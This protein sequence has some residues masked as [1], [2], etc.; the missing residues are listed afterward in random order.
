MIQ[1]PGTSSPPSRLKYFSNG[2][3]RTCKASFTSSF[4]P[5]LTVDSSG[6][7]GGSPTHAPL[8]QT[9]PSSPSRRHALLGKLAS[10]HC[11]KSCLSYKSVLSA[12]E[13]LSTVIE[14]WNEYQRCSH[15]GYWTDPGTVQIHQ[16]CESF[17]AKHGNILITH[18]ARGSTFSNA[19]ITHSWLSGIQLTNTWYSFFVW[20][21]KWLRN[22]RVTFCLLTRIS[23]LVH[24]S[25]S[26][27]FG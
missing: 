4:C 22:S 26:C 12:I 25:C 19:W 21:Y 23:V 20:C 17:C 14:L 27:I 15:A 1:Q 16:N 13:H 6:S 8:Q 10:S 24:A 9:S 7:S 11:F 3:I 2:I 18:S 5:L